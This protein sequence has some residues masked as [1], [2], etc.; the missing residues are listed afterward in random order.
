MTSKVSHTRYEAL[1][2]ERVHGVKISTQR[3]LYATLLLHNFR[4][5][6]K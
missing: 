5:E 3:E 2:P 1:G 4:N 6:T